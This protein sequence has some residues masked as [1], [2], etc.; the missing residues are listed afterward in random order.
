MNITIER[1]REIF[2]SAEINSD[3]AAKLDADETLKSQGID[4][5]DMATF[6]F[7]IEE[8]TGISIPHTEYKKLVSLRE[9]ARILSENGSAWGGKS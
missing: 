8:A 1:L 5:L 7:F 4:S 2:D 9:I 6:V 3:G